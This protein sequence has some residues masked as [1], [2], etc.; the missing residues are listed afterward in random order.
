MHAGMTGSTS[1]GN[2][3]DGPQRAGR[4]S[5]EPLSPDPSSKTLGE[6]GSD[7]PSPSQQPSRPPAR[8][9]ATEY[10]EEGTNKTVPHPK[11]DNGPSEDLGGRQ[12][13]IPNSP[14]T[15]G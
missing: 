4:T 5:D 10:G 7:E 13:H 1:I 6:A 9:D 2:A 3:P 12:P 15:R 14:Y 11:P 8:P